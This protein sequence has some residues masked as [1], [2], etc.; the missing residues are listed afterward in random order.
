MD[1]PYA[2]WLH[3]AK[4]LPVGQSRRV[5]HRFERRENMVVRNLPEGWSCYCHA[6]GEGGFKPKEFVKITEQAEPEQYH[7]FIPNDL[8]PLEDLDRFRQ[9]RVYG[10][11]AQKGMDSVYFNGVLVRY[12]PSKDRVV[13]RLSGPDGY[14]WLGRAVG[15]QQPKWVAYSTPTTGY[16]EYC[17]SIKRPPPHPE[18]PV[19]YVVVEDPFSMLKVSWACPHVLVTCSLGTRLHPRLLRSLLGWADVRVWYDGDKAGEQGADKAVRRLQGLGVQAKALTVP[20][21]DPKDMMIKEIRELL[22]DTCEPNRTG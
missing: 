22:Y 20:G 17:T 12:S 3:M 14:A 21:K 4:R 18:D 5:K 16:A 15:G 13:L 1:I 7:Q 6:C 8:V 19:P 9:S 2:E 11:L 10:F